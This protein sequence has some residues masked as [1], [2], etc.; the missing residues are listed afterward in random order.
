[1][2]A[3]MCDSKFGKAFRSA[4]AQTIPLS[5]LDAGDPTRLA[6]SGDQEVVRPLM[7][8]D[9]LDHFLIKTSIKA[10]PILWAAMCIAAGTSAEG[11]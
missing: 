11:K 5:Q 2:P 3:E 1:M 8:R 6:A 4:V 7:A 9:R 10:A